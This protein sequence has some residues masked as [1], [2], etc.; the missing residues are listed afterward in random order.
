M[1]QVDSVKRIMMGQVHPW[2]KRQKEEYCGADQLESME[3]VSIGVVC[4][5]PCSERFS[6]FFSGFPPSAKINPQIQMFR[7]QIWVVWRKPAAPVVVSFRFSH[8]QLRPSIVV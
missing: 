2:R 7:G 8:V 4:S 6:P 5:L 3:L 1:M